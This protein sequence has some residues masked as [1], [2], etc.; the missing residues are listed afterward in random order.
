MPLMGSIAVPQ[1]K[2][3]LCAVEGGCAGEMYAH[4]VSILIRRQDFFY[5]N[6]DKFTVL[7]TEAES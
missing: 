4:T 2:F 5:G 7:V 3:F 6:R 1:G